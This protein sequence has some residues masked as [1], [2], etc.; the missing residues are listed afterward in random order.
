MKLG[1]D[2]QLLE[3]SGYAHYTNAYMDLTENLESDAQQLE[4]DVAQ[5]IAK[6]GVLS[7]DSLNLIS[8]K[9]LMSS[10]IITDEH[11]NYSAIITACAKMIEENNAALQEQLKQLGILQ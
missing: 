10:R 3:A 9:S 8:K 7:V 1:S 11:N 4:E 6:S 5:A 2:P